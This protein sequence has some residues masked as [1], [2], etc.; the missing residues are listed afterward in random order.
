MSKNDYEKVKN[1]KR[2]VYPVDSGG[3]DDNLADLG[4][5]AQ[6]AGVWTNDELPGRGWNMIA[7]PFI[8]PPEAKFPFNYRLLLNQ[9]NET[10]VFST[11]DGP[12]PNR[13]IQVGAAPTNADQQLMA[14]SYEQNIVQ[15]AAA[16]FPHSNQAGGKNLP[17]HHEPGLFLRILNAQTN[18]LDIARLATIPHGDSV[19]AMGRSSSAVGVPKIPVTSGLPIGVSDDVDNNPYL[20][21]YKHFRDNKFQGLFD[22]TQPQALLEAANAGVN[23]VKSTE[24]G[25]DST[26]ETGGISN[27]P[28]VVRQANA[29]TMK[30]TFWIQEVQD[31]KKTKLRLQYLQ[32]VMLDFFGRRDGLPGRI[33]WPHVSINTMTKLTTKHSDRF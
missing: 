20:G 31:G 3:D 2:S 5:L 11:I 8:A 33:G 29:A 22:P 25:F 1:K 10:L 28:F 17:I 6:L 19:L 27:I 16:D 26:L 24:L 13:G 15:I 32:V 12:V 23:I 18:G 14:L 21:P 4:P 9:Y 30:A 7:L